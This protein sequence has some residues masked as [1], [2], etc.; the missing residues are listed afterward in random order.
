MTLIPLLYDNKWMTC[1]AS[2][3]VVAA[4]RRAREREENTQSACPIRRI[5]FEGESKEAVL[6]FIVIEK[7]A[8]ATLMDDLGDKWPRNFRI[9]FRCL[10]RFTLERAGIGIYRLEIFQF[11]ERWGKKGMRLRRRTFFESASGKATC[12]LYTF[13]DIMQILS[14]LFNE[15]THFI[16]FCH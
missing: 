12:H 14:S 2:V 9:C 11:F 10:L 15:T 7:R 3:S 8:P 4:L 1:T 16:K 5:T 6:T 13:L